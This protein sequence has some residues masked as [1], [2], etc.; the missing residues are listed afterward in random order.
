MGGFT[1]NGDQVMDELRE[2]ATK[3]LLVAAITL[4]T[5]HVKDLN[6]SNPRPHRNPAPR[7]EFPRKRT[8][9]L[10]AGILIDPPDLQA[11]KATLSVRVGYSRNADYGAYLGAKG[12]KWIIDTLTRVEGR[13]AQLTG[14]QVSASEG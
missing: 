6:K 3:L 8:G 4:Q 5:E 13:I 9:N 1:W 2:D 14:G 7:G 12:W 10:Q 11:I